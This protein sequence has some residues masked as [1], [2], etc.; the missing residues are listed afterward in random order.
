VGI[1]GYEDFIQ[2]DAAINPGNSGGP[3]VNIE[4]QVIGIT[5]AIATRSGG[6]QGI[7]FAIPSNSAKLVMDE[8]IKHGK[9]TRGLLGVNIQDLNES[10]AKSFGLSDTNGALVA[11]VIAGSPAEKAGI[12]AGDVIL[13]MDGKVVTGAAELKNLVGQVRPGAAVKLTVHRDKK[14]FDVSATV[15]ERTPKALAEAPTGSAGSAATSTDLGV[16]LEKVPA[17][18]AE[19][20]GIKEGVGLAIKQVNPDSVGGKMGLREGDVILEIDGKAASDVS[21]FNQEVKEAKKNKV[22][23]LKIQRGSATIFLGTELD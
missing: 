13:K 11:Q 15:S 18:A 7:G 19:K 17:A 2:T 5:T 20:M 12:K 22:I 23:R 1:I 4:G 14:T 10:L 21:A 8:L 6:Y 9:V 3:L 16:T